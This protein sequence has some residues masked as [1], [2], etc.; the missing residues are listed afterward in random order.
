MQFVALDVETT[1]TLSYTDHIVELAA[2][3]FS[4]GK[5]TNKFSTLINPGVS[6]PEEASRV[7]GITDEMLKNQPV[8]SDVL[9]NF[10]DFCGNSPLVAHNAIFDFQFL[11]QALEKNY[12]IA[13]QG[14]LLDTYAL[15]KKVF[16]G[17]SNYKLST[18]VEYL[19]IP[20]SHF[21]R[22]E[23]DAWACGQVF[24]SILKKI[25]LRA[26]ENGYLDCN[27][28]S[29]LAGKKELRFPPLKAHQLSFFD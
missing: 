1:G 4:N 12:C 19:K 10:S 8:I 13:P 24:C 17:L 11:S 28:L 15:S 26:L 5:V 22:A 23:Q 6:M 3:C 20:V 27:K 25:N 29:Q 7:N 18:L 16:P 14:P 21:H 9:K 2:I